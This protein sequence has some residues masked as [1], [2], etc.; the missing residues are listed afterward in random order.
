MSD[1]P[2]AIFLQLAMQAAENMLHTATSALTML[3]KVE[4]VV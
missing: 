2:D 3:R 4:E 1:L